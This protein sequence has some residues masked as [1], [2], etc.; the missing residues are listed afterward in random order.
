MRLTGQVALVTGAGSGIGRAAALLLAQEGARV[1]ALDIVEASARQTADEIARAGG[2]AMALVADISDAGQIRAAIERL[3]K[4]WSRLTIVVANAGINGVWATIEELEP[5]DWDHTMDVNARGTFLTLKYAVPYLK[6]QGGAAVVTSSVNGTRSFSLT[7]AT[8][9]ACSK[10]AQATMAKMLAL[11]LAR[12]K[13][14]VNVICPGSTA[15]NIDVNTDYRPSAVDARLLPE[16]PGG[17]VPLTGPTFCSPEQVA[18]AILFL[19]SD[20]A[21]HIS[22]T[23]LFIDGAESLLY[24]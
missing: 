12:H 5:E 15:T 9:Y 14:R 22:G 8:A 4:R 20:A 3:V 24:G 11:E 21:S 1:A 13:V 19:V 2:E 16:V 6:R 18:Q 17:G 10:A 7:G 23:E